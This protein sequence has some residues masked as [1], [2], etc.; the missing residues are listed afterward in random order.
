MNGAIP[1]ADDVPV[2]SAA[3]GFTNPFTAIG[4]FGQ[5]KNEK[6]KGFV[7]DAAA[8]ALGKMLNRFARKEKVP[9]INVVR[10]KEHEELLKKEGCEHIVVTEG[11]WKPKYDALVKSLG[12]DTLIDCLGSGE[13]LDKLVKGLPPGGLVIIISNLEGGKPIIDMSKPQKVQVD[14]YV[15]QPWTLY[16]W[17][18]NVTP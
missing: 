3:Y 9:V 4:L 17:F 6:R 1:I 12:V 14:K 15:F 16:Q 5:I 2:Q 11:D 7:L 18:K 13:V 10:K 8:S